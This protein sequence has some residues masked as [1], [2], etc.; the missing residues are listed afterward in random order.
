MNDESSML[1]ENYLEA[2]DQG[3]LTIADCLER[4][5]EMDPE[6]VSILELVA[7]M[8]GVPLPEPTL[9]FKEESKR[10]VLQSFSNNS[11]LCLRQRFYRFL[12][13][14]TSIFRMSPGRQLALVALLLVVLLS[15]SSLYAAA[16]SVPGKPFY[17]V[18]L[19]V[20]D[21]Q[22]RLTDSSAEV[23]LYLQFAE[24]RLREVDTLVNAGDYDAIPAVM[25]RFVSHV[26]E[27]AEKLPLQV[28]KSA[29][30]VEEKSIALNENLHNHIAVLQDLLEVVPE[31]AK[32][33]IENAIQVSNK[34]QEKLKERFPEGKP[35]GG[36]GEGGKPDDPPA[37]P[38]PDAGPPPGVPQGP[39]GGSG[40]PGGGPPGGSPGKPPKGKP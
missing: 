28:P 11:R 8:K 40:N 7:E 29:S 12:E 20:E 25:N 10:R 22:L 32:P 35:G 9:Q 18:K 38:P 5:P 16:E 17:P 36:Q 30:Q 26:E 4:F 33:A 23:P 19:L 13:N 15:G 3:E 27:A 6:I 31:Q 14:L 21:T 39:P 1:L 37:G 2:I 34:G 24:E